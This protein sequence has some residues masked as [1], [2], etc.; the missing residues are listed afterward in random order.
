M[1]KKI[2]TN[3][4]FFVV[5]LMLICINCVP[6]ATSYYIQNNTGWGGRYNI[7]NIEGLIAWETAIRITGYSLLVIISCLVVRILLLCI[8]KITAF[9]F[10]VGSVLNFSVFAF[11]LSVVTDRI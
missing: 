8:K 3:N 9:E 6:I 10:F 5:P 2:R 1:S 7:F 11:Y 4:P